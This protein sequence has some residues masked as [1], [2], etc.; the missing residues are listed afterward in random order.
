LTSV[1]QHSADKASWNAQKEQFANVQREWDQL[2]ERQRSDVDTLQKDK[3]LLGTEVV[4]LR[5]D[6]SRVADDLSKVQGQFDSLA[7]TRDEAVALTRRAQE[8]RQVALDAEQS[9]Q[10]QLGDLKKQQ[11]TLQSAITRLTGER[12]SIQLAVNTTQSTLDIQKTELAKRTQDLM[13]IDERVTAAREELRKQNAALVTV[14]EEVVKLLAQRQSARNDIADATDE[15]DR[16]AKAKREMATLN[17]QLQAL[18]TEKASIESDLAKD[19]ARLQHAKVKLADYVEQWKTRDSIVKEVSTLRSDQT[20]L[21]SDKV[22]LEAA[23]ATLNEKQSELAAGLALKEKQSADLQSRIDE[24]R[25]ED[26]RLSATVLAKTKTI[27][28]ESASAPMDTA[29]NN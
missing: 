18:K 27:K 28:E 7:S 25:K 17:G 10:R 2:G 19:E 15:S 20:K 9:I 8:Q 22:M 16:V 26:I 5:E 24:L 6:R 21:A 3:E 29:K 23:I 4:K 13:A 11:E 1:L 14:S 12:D